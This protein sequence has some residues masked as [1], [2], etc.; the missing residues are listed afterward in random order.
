MCWPGVL[1]GYSICV[2]LVMVLVS[3]PLLGVA[4]LVLVSM[5]CASVTALYLSILLLGIVGYVVLGS[6]VHTTSQPGVL[7]VYEAA[8]R[9]YYHCM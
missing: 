9:T 6:A 7:P 3:R 4:A 2:L 5:H 8:S 1:V